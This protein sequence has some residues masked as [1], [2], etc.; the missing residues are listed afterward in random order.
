G[1]Q[2]GQGRRRRMSQIGAQT[3]Q[4][5]QVRIVPS[6]EHL[7]Q[8]GRGGHG[9]GRAGHPHQSTAPRSAVNFALRR[10]LRPALAFIPCERKSRFLCPPARSSSSRPTAASASSA[11]TTAARSFCMPPPCRRSEE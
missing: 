11:P 1:S 9:R 4:L 2:R 8:I 10:Y 3:E 7:G 6:R 5:L